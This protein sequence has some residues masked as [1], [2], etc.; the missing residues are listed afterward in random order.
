MPDVGGASSPRAAGS[1]NT[2]AAVF[3]RRLFW[4]RQVRARPNA[5]NSHSLP[6]DQASRESGEIY[7]IS[8]KET[9]DETRVRCMP[10]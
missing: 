6:K 4:R 3:E 9:S 7:R 8:F 5:R 10:R 1:Y 2:L